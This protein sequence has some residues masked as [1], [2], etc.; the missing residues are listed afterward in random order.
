MSHYEIR[1]ALAQRHRIVITRIHLLY[2]LKDN[3]F[4]RRKDYADLGC[5]TDFVQQQLQGTGKMHGHSSIDGFSWKI[6]WLNAYKTSRDPRIVGGYFL[7]GLESLSRCPELVR[8]D[9]GTEY[10]L[11]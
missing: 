3:R 5:V 6:I 8:T 10:C 9:R 7:E 1:I 4:S 11:V 2:I